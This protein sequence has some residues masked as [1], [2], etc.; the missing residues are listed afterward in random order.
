M[1][2]EANIDGVYNLYEAA[3]AHGQP[4]I[5]FASSNHAVGFHSQT[6]RLDAESRT[7]PDGLFGV[8]KVFG[9]AMASMY[10]DKF[11]Q[12]TTIVRSGSILPEPANHRMLSTWF[13]FDD[14][15]SLIRQSFDVPKLGCP[16]VYGASGND[17]SWWD[18]GKTRYLGWVPNDNS[19]VFRA[20]LDATMDRPAPDAPD[21]VYQGGFFA[22]DG[23]HK[24][25]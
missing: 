5:I 9:E 16:I 22:T 1:T 10:Y 19:E 20:K 14:F 4:R 17:A 24:D 2:R 12:E 23:I 18:N 21:A 3:R 6:S 7:R 15:T 13:S 8:S 11:G 25:D